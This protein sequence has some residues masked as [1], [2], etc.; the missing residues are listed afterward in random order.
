MLTTV[1]ADDGVPLAVQEFGRRDAE[2][3]LVFVHGHCLH[4]QSWAVLRAHLADADVRMIC[5]DHRG[6]GASGHADV[7]T[8]TIDQL[9]RDLHAVL[10]ATTPSGPVVLVGHSMGAMTA[11]AYARLFAEQ[12]G[13]R[14][15]GIG[16]IASAASGVATLGLGRLLSHP[17]VR[18]L[19]AAVRRAPNAMHTSRQLGRFA[20]APIVR[21]AAHPGILA[22]ANALLNETSV[23]T[24]SS[25]LDSIVAFDETETLAT[26]DIPTLVLCGE[27]DQVTPFEHSAAIAQRLR[28]AQLVCVDG[29]GHGLILDRA[30]DVAAHI[31]NLVHRTRRSAPASL[32]G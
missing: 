15:V 32:A 31:M 5:Y 7:E 4:A 6:H 27:A 3:T 25:F 26:L 2:V 10:E 24:M 30:A 19:R 12:L 18:V 23:V 13:G 29:A 9:A 14:V 22:L 17:V 8:Y 1:Y 20:C 21:R 28:D 11:M 16:L